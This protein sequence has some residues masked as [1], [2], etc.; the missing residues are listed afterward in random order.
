MRASH[1]RAA[2]LLAAA[3]L[4]IAC[5]ACGSSAPGGGA[6]SG[7]N[8]SL[9]KGTSGGT[10]GGL[11][12]SGFPVTVQAANGRVHVGARPGAIVS[13]SPTL[14]EMLYAIGAGGQV[15]AVDEDSDYPPQAPRTKLNGFQ[16]NLEAIVAFKPDLVVLSD[17]T[18]GLARRLAGLSVPVLVLPPATALAQVYAEIDELGQATGHLP[19][20]RHEAASIAA[21]IRQIVAAAPHHG[22]PLTYYYELDQTYYSVASDTFVGRLLGLLGMKSIADTAKGAASSGGY[23]QLSSEFIVRANPDYIIL[24]DTVCCHQDAATVGRRPGW[25]SLA[26]VRDGHVIGLNDDIASRW[27]PR[28]VDLLRTVETAIA[29]AGKH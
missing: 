16:P 28:I 1:R 17:N 26:A 15:K 7:S 5:A 23:P 4:A 11:Q 24:A 14:T 9:T 13:L 22:K 29:R 12:S 8:G 21:G 27:G 3:V 6:A 19:Q 18:N 10:S 20:A 25:A 2:G